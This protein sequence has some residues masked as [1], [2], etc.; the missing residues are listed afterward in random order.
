[1]ENMTPNP[2]IDSSSG[3]ICTRIS[4]SP[5]LSLGR[6]LAFRADVEFRHRPCLSLGSGS[7]R[8]IFRDIL[9]QPF[10]LE[11]LPPLCIADPSC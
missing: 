9:D 6:A 5:M 10:H 3:I 4:M 11:D 7:D 2:R 1:M 8:A